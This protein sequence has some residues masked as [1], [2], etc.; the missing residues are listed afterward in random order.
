MF[1]M[2]PETI[3]FLIGKA[4]EF[5]AK[6]EVVIPDVPYSPADDWARQILADHLDDPTYREVQYAIEDLEPDQRA[7]V[8]ALA[9]L[10]RGDY[11]LEEW[12]AAVKAANDELSPGLVNRLMS[13]PLIADYWEDGLRQHGYSC[14]E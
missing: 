1:D 7:I 12:D 3:C 2:N 4:H 10:G 6:E 11:S 9:W 8:L 14:E 5:H 13:I